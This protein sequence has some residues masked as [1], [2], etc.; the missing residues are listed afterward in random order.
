M[1]IR[2]NFTGEIKNKVFTKLLEVCLAVF[3][4]QICCCV[5]TAFK[6]SPPPPPP[7]QKHKAVQAEVG[8]FYFPS[9]V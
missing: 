1:R 8:G 2:G 9:N 3:T 6:S 5:D 7:R 4:P